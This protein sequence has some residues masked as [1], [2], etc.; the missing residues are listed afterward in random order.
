MR[1]KFLNREKSLHLDRLIAIPEITTF[2]GCLLKAATAGID[3]TVIVTPRQIR[4]VN[5]IRVNAK[6]DH[7]IDLVQFG[8]GEWST[9]TCTL[10]NTNNP[11]AGSGNQGASQEN[12][13][14]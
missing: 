4:V 3:R 10:S 14:K 13:K 8:P 2:A 1:D 11:W 6:D 12:N 5:S 7:A 9:Y